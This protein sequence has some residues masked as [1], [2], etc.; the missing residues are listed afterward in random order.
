MDKQ[1]TDI[2]VR[3]LTMNLLTFN[4]SLELCA[5][6][7]YEQ[8]NLD[9][10]DGLPENAIFYDLGSCEGRFAIYAG[11]KGK[12]VYA[13]EP[14]KDNFET[15]KANITNNNLVGQV[16][17]FNVGVGEKNEDGI[18]NIGQPWP[19]GHQ[20][21]VESTIHRSDLDFDFK[22]NQ[23]IQIVGLDTFIEQNQLENPDYLKV[24]IDGSEIP[25]LKGASKTLEKVKKLIFELNKNDENYQNILSNLESKGLKFES[26][27]E[28]P[29]E[30]NL[31]NIVFSR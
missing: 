29:N 22:T 14:E 6:M 17:A 1:T 19:G 8:E 18:L 31:Y 20:K 13:F 2:D 24:D 16:I 10:I 30:P 3:G 11:L 5:R 9:F 21:I 12:R 4:R 27:H 15:L 23:K 25:F 7:N 26:E 28:V